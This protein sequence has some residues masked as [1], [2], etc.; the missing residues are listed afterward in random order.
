M[1][2]YCGCISNPHAWSL[3]FPEKCTLYNT[4]CV[5]DLVLPLI[6]NYI[7]QVTLA[8]LVKC[9]RLI[10]HCDFKNEKKNK[11]SLASCH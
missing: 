4:T 11:T 7:S 10:F 2:S 5:C 8:L 9:F 6:F 1:P 3:F